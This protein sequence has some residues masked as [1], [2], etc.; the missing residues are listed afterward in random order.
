MTGVGRYLFELVRGLPNRLW[1]AWLRAEAEFMEE[2][3]RY[4]DRDG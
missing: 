4:G 3:Q 2:N 1:A